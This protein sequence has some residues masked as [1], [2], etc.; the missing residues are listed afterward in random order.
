[1]YD[2]IRQHFHQPHM[3]NNDR[4]SVAECL[5]CTRDLS[6]NKNQR[7]VPLFPPAGTLNFF[8]A[9]NFS[10]PDKMKVGNNYISVIIDSQSTLIEIIQSARTT[11]T[12]I[13]NIFMEQWVAASGVLSTVLTNNRPHF[14]FK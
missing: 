3:A 13:A 7:K 14:T 11:A 6:T 5:L 12:R 10:H 4:K 1:M 8:A 2:T 9:Y